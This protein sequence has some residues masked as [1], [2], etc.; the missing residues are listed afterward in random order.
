MQN[1]LEGADKTKWVA[2]KFDCT[3][4]NVY[5]AEFQSAANVVSTVSGTAKK[6]IT[7][8]P[9]NTLVHD[10]FSGSIKPL[11]NDNSFRRTVTFYI[12][13]IADGGATF[14]SE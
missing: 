3:S 12:H 1:N 2:Y 14:M 6:A 5:S 7:V 10:T 9:S 4:N 13:S 11:L 8:G